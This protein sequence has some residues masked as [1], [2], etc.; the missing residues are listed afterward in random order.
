[1]FYTGGMEM[2]PDA[3]VHFFPYI[4]KFQGTHM[5]VLCK[6]EF[7]KSTCYT[8]TL[9]PKGSRTLTISFTALYGHGWISKHCPL[10]LTQGCS[11]KL[12]ILML[13]PLGPEISTGKKL[14]WRGELGIKGKFKCWQVFCGFKENS[15]IIKDYFT[16]HS[17]H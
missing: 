7:I 13:H 6:L 14:E 8:K 11:M 4:L 1:M 16:D 9:S 5:T 3:L 2:T 10:I 15:L 12:V 17:L